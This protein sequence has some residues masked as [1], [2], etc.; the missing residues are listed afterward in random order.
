MTGIYIAGGL[1]VGA[2]IWAI[3]TFNSL[4]RARNRV[5]ESWSGVDVQL[6]RRCDL[7]PNLVAAVQGYAQHER[8]LL[9]AV[10]VARAAVLEA[11]A[12]DQRERGESGLSALLGRL[13]AVAENYPDLKASANFIALQRDLT[14]VKNEI[15]AARNIYN[16]NVR[17]LN[18][19]I[20]SFPSSIVAGLAKFDCRSFFTLDVDADRGVPVVALA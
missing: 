3:A 14:E 16:S 6:K 1:I 20:E 13:M 18:T 8:S 5:D 11:G 12:R 15:Q 19:K 9:E 7:V 2:A 4:V 17:F 10:T